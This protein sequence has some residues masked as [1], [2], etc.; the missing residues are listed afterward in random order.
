M[1]VNCGPDSSK[2]K[3]EGWSQPMLVRSLWFIK[4]KNSS[5]HLIHNF[6]LMPE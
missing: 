4:N 6:F 1:T 2:V 5:L 3:C